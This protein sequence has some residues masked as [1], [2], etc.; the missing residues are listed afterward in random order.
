[1]QQTNKWQARL[2]F[3]HLEKNLRLHNSFSENYEIETKN[4]HKD[5]IFGNRASQL[6]PCVESCVKSPKSLPGGPRSHECDNKQKID[7]VTQ[8][9][10]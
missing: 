2:P 8:I 1:M 6:C 4:Q 5:A 10:P 7:F 3:L 9:C